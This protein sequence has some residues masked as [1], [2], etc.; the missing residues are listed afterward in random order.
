MIDVN[1]SA[2]DTKTGEKEPIVYFNQE[3]FEA[4]LEK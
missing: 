4:R 3:T 1:G 2:V